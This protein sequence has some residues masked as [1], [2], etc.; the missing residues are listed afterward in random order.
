MNTRN[1]EY[2]EDASECAQDLWRSTRGTPEDAGGTVGT[3]YYPGTDTSISRQDGTRRWRIRGTRTV[4][5]EVTLEPTAADVL[6]QFGHWRWTYNL[7][8]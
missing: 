6:A 3:L 8:D 7:G 4:Y 1:K 2:L 5:R